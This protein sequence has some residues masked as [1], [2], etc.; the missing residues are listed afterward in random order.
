MRGLFK[1]ISTIVRATTVLAVLSTG[2]AAQTLPIT[3]KILEGNGAINN[4][5]RRTAYSPVVQV[6]DRDNRPLAQIPVT[7]T[8]PGIG[9]GGRFTDGGTT[10]TVTTDEEGKAVAR[11]LTPNSTAGAFEIRVTAAY[12]GRTARAVVNQTNAAPVKAESGH[13]RR[14]LIIGLIAG[15]AA[16]G[17]I[18]AQSG[19]GGSQQ[20]AAR[21]PAAD[22]PVVGVVSPGQPGFGPPQ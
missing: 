9:P 1:R 18:A 22:P 20:P 4:I 13:T 10:L 7:F 2:A 5:S 15:A 17:L 8:V 6:L 19:G 16:G 3:I 14:L 21:P 11:G 12:Q